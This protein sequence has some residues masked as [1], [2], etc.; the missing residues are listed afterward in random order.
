[1]G[2]KKIILNWLDIDPETIKKENRKQTIQQ[3]EDFIIGVVTL[4]RGH[5]SHYAYDDMS[6]SSKDFVMLV[7][8]TVDQQLISHTKSVR[9]EIQD[10]VTSDEFLKTIIS[11]I[12]EYQLK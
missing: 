5:S 3:F 1:M 2:I 11:N 4:G 7:K 6:N 12:N 8:N 9:G 10:V